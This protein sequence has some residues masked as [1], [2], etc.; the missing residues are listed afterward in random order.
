VFYSEK[1]KENSGVKA[2]E[3]EVRTCVLQP[4]VR[5]L[6]RCGSLGKG[7]GMA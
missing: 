5:L 6:F 7:L 3:K 4:S 2:E 1:D